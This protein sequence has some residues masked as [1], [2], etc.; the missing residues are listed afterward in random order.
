MAHPE[1]FSITR[2]GAFAVPKHHGK[3]HHFEWE[4]MENYGKIHHFLAGK[5][6]KPWKDP[7]CY[8]AG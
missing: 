2:P 4:T 8:L 3:I 1:E 6:K 5:P 7:P